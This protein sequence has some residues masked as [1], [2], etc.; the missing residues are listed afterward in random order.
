[1]SAQYIVA[2]PFGGSYTNAANADSL[3]IGL[4]QVGPFN[5][6]VFAA[7]FHPLV[8]TMLANLNSGG[9]EGFFAYAA[10]QNQAGD[11]GA[12]FVSDYA[13]VTDPNNMGNVI[14]L[15]LPA[16][17][18]D[19]SQDGAY[20]GYNWELFFHGPLL[21]ATTLSSNGQYADAMA[22]FQYVFN[23][24]SS[25]A[26]DPTY[27]N[28][29]AQYWNFVPFKNAGTADIAA[30]LSGLSPDPGQTGINPATGQPAS[31]PTIYDWMQQPFNPFAIA[32]GRIVAFMKNVVMKFLDNVIAWGDSYY[33][34]PTME[35]IT[36]A[37]QL[38]VMA[39]Q[40]L[41]PQPQSVPSRG[42]TAS[43]SFNSISSLLDDFSNALVQL[44]NIFPFS[45]PITAPTTPYT[46]NNLLG[47]GNTLY[48]CVPDNDHL[49]QYWTTVGGRLFNIR[50]C[51]NM[52][53]LDMTLALFQPIINPALLVQ[54][55]AQ[56]ISIESVLSDMDTPAPLYR[57]TYLMQKATEFCAEVKSL[58]AGLLSAIEKGDNEEL[59]RLRSVHEANLLNMMTEVKN[60][61]VLEAQSAI[62]GLTKSREIA[63][64]H[65]QHY[66]DVMLGNTDISI[67]AAPGLPGELTATTALPA[68]TVIADVTC[69][70]DVSLSIDSGAVLIPMEQN[71]LS[72]LNTANDFLLSAT[73]AEGLAGGLRI[74]PQ[75][76]AHAT[77]LGVGVALGFGGVQLGGMAESAAKVLQTFASEYTYQANVS[78]KM[79]GYFRREQEWVYQANL[80]IREIIQLDK[81]L[82]SAQVRLQIAQYE[83]KNHLEQVSNANDIVTFLKGGSVPGYNTKFSTVEMY[84]WLKN[85][86]FTI[87]QQSYQ[88]AYALA[89]KAEK[90]YQFELGIQGTSFIQYGYWNSTYQ[91]LVS[92]EQLHLALKQMDQSYIEENVRELELTKHISLSLVAPDALFELIQT[93]SCQISLPEELFDLDFPGH[94]FRR[95]KS[96]SI[97]IPAVAGP[98]TTINASLYLLQ[99]SIRINSD[100][101]TGN[102]SYPQSSVNGVPAN[103]ARFIQ[104]AVP[105][106]SI[107][108]S[109]AQNDSGTFELNFRDERYLP[110]EGAGVISQWELQLNGKYVTD[111][112][113][114]IDISQF[115]YDTISDIILHVRY[116]ARVDDTLQSAVYAHLQSY[117]T[118]GPFLRLF[119][120]KTDFPEAFYQLF[121]S[122]GGVQS[123]QL[124]LSALNFPFVFQNQ[125]KGIQVVQLT[126]YIEPANAGVA[127]SQPISLS[128]FGQTAV[129][130]KDPFNNDSNMLQG[131]CNLSG[132]LA[133]SSLNTTIQASGLV[134]TQIG[135][136][137]IIVQFNT[138][139]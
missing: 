20:S 55:A 26:P 136:I 27:T 69:T 45:S 21:I 38:Y 132:P 28:P 123:T 32:R 19:F 139:A 56:G 16:I 37:T 66:N 40:V 133:L 83:L 62:D 4:V 11:I 58:G 118:N 104:N 90:A 75:V 81:Q 79:A 46:G 44:E 14:Q 15:P 2:P 47:I 82:V 12:Q 130:S 94:Y 78:A 22:W 10:S 3:G 73:T 106:T 95:I 68:D 86:L 87:Y 41:G 7:F 84:G 116:T 76:G 9:L 49:L 54:A 30:L 117:I 35:S 51:L 115:D 52:Q 53:G 1:M 113:K 105:F 42:T 134:Q 103:D 125:S 96:V 124:N 50:H 112:N 59:G 77:P 101:P 60:R 93:G 128:I 63:Q 17:N 99:N 57:F 111:K 33:A 89:K 39:S 34:N 119:S 121:N 138:N 91:G 5:Q 127:I 80:A 85:Q 18:I 100:L 102:G 23:P 74:I 25:T 31:D 110:F 43:Y 137:L 48:F 24:F 88:M 131:L 107:A 8:S 29:M 98:Y 129:I 126:A 97:T 61:Q 122:P 114:L 120:M 109:S 70:V 71:E 36:Q 135:D 67:P 72:Y 92:G 108:T 64:Y 6:L 65:L 13:P